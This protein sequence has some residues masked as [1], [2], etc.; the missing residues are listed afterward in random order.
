MKHHSLT[1]PVAMAVASLLFMPISGF[2]QSILKTAGNYSALAGQA[3][4]VAGAGFTLTNGNVGLYPA[5]TSSI[6]GF[7]P[8]TVSGTT[9]LGTA[10]AIISTG[11]ATQ[12]AEADLQ[13]AA[14]GLAAMAPNANYSNVDMANVGALPPGV[15]KWNAAATLTGA[16]V[17]DAQ[18]RNNV[19]WVFQFGTGLTTAVNSTVTVIN[20][21]SNGGSDD[22]IF[23]NAASGAITIGDNNTVLG[24]Y[25]AFT[26]ISFTGSTLL[27]GGTGTRFLALNAAISFA[28]PG[29][30]NPLGAPGGGDWTGGLTLSGSSVVASTS[31]APPSGGAPVIT[32]PG[33]ISGMAGAPF[34]TSIA[35][36]GQPTSYSASGLPA[37]LVLNPQTG[38]ITGTPTASGTFLV[39]IAATN[40]SGTTT[41][42]LTI[43]IG[44]LAY[45]R[46][47]NF[48]ARA[49]SGTGSDTL[50]VGFV[51]SPGAKSLLLRGV[52]PALAAFGI[53][54][55]LNDPMLNLDGSSGQIA[56]N[57]SWQTNSGG[58]AQGS[59]ITA[60]DTQVGAFALPSGSTDAALVAA[61]SGGTYTASI[62]SPN[63]TSGIALAEIY[64]ADTAP[65]PSARLINVSARMN[66][67]A[68]QGTL[69]AG[70]VIEGN[71]P[72]T[73]LIRGVGPALTAFG[74]AGVLP[75]PQITV[76]SG[77]TS[78][79]T[80]AGW[81][82]GSSSASQLS[83]AA[84]QV[85]AFPLP[86]GSKDSAVLITLQP[87]A[88]T[89]VVTSV[90][91]ATGVALVEVYDTQ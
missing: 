11:G 85:G 43:A 51:V 58:Q 45:A 27:N 19:F 16:L 2:G 20:P 31:S 33:T 79:A 44:P 23:W 71:I 29:S 49:M 3:I 59:L 18:G 40:S 60:S 34:S 69:I 47:A 70:L 7:P 36:T 25:I 65:N 46:I 50:I 8:G 56:T 81:G 91:G 76:L 88:Y 1:L 52:G 39:T 78:V 15:Y 28:G 72:Q 24:N 67:T 35:A 26:S 12:Q 37:G 9:L 90:S 54:G 48:S 75:D 86:S 38:A 10:A 84:A 77:S 17:L 42:S 83:A 82:T 4:T 22:G 80:N 6:T 32:S 55:P 66:V 64:D 14:T 74:V 21:G 73:V 53:S 41:S 61:V 63:G 57:D 68:G 87:G 30:I 13:V 62:L 89:V 5:A